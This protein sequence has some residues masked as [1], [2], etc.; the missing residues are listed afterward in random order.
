MLR[1]LIAL[2]IISVYIPVIAQNDTLKQKPLRVVVV[3]LVHD[4]VGL[5]TWIPKQKGY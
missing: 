2:F 4:H 5:D 3:G 1:F